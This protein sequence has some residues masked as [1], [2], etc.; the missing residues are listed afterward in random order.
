MCIG[1]TFLE[2]EDREA[3]AALLF[4]GGGRGLDRRGKLNPD[5]LVDEGSGKGQERPTFATFG[6]ERQRSA[7]QAGGDMGGKFGDGYLVFRKNV[8]KPA[9]VTVKGEGSL[10]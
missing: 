2:A 5:P 9:K 6:A 1:V 8:L 10:N 4:S 3:L 7:A